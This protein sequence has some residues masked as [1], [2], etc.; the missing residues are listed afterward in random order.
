MPK[1]DDVILK[2]T[3]EWVQAVVVDL[4][5]CPFTSSTAARAGVPIG[6]FATL[7]TGTGPGNGTA[8]MEDAGACSPP[9]HP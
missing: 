9:F 5:I 3:F 2:K 8:V 7:C 4:G 6:A 1:E